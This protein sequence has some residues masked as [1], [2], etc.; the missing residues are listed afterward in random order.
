MFHR[1][2]I[3]RLL[4]CITLS[5]QVTDGL[6]YFPQGPHVDE[7]HSRSLT[8]FEGNQITTFALS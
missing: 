3:L 5:T 4:H 6:Q 2:I 1:P 7:P 8:A